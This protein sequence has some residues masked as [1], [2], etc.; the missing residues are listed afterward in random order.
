[1][2][3]TEKSIEILPKHNGAGLISKS[4]ALNLKISK[5]LTKI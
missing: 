1:M 3:S 5:S 4:F 2:L